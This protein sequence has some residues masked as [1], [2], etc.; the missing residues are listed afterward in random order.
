MWETLGPWLATGGAGAILWTFI[1]LV[2]IAVATERRRADDWHETANT[3]EAANQVNTAN[4]EKLIV[5]VEQLAASQ[6]ETFALLKGLASDR[7]GVT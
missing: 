5:L 1:R 4:V 2:N 7:R 3:R 6:R